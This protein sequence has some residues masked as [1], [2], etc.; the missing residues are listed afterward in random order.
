[1]EE[2]SFFGANGVG[3]RGFQIVIRTWFQS[4]TALVYP[5]LSFHTTSYEDGGRTMQ[6]PLV[7]KFLCY[8][9][10]AAR[11]EL[12]WISHPRQILV[13]NGYWRVSNGYRARLQYPMDTG[14]SSMDTSAE[15]ELTTHC[16][17]PLE[18]SF[19]HNFAD[20]LV[21][22]EAKAIRSRSNFIE[23]KIPK[24]TLKHLFLVPMES[25]RGGFE[26]LLEH[27]SKAQPP[28]CILWYPFTQL[29]T[30]MEAGRCKCLWFQS[31]FDVLCGLINY[32]WVA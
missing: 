23:I 22:V 15:R 7:S 31:S 3:Q 1:M 12:G 2:T 21:I 19:C 5:L 24:P 11:M 18:G 14:T 4:P 29:A 25:G 32:F 13:S 16:K 10:A 9:E 28:L 27:D 20:P 17:D 30:R 6:M 8:L 26:S